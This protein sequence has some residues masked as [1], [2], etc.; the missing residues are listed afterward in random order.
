MKLFRCE[1]KEITDN[2]EKALCLCDMSDHCEFCRRL[3]AQYEPARIY[4]GSYFCEKY[5][6]GINIWTRITDFCK[7]SNIHISMV[8]PVF[9]QLDLNN[10]KTVISG[11]ISKYSDIIDE[12]VVNDFG[13]LRFI[14]QISDLKIIQG[15]LFSKIPRD[16]RFTGQSSGLKN[17]EVQVFDSAIHSVE[18]D[19]VGS[20]IYIIN[21]Q[22]L[23]IGLQLHVPYCYQTVGNI[24]CY[25]STHK[26]IEKKFRPN[27]SCERECYYLCEHYKD[28]DI[29]KIG[30]AVYFSSDFTK[31][32][33]I[34]VER[35]IY[36][37]IREYL[38]FMNGQEVY[39]CENFS[40]LK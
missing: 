20:N 29:A 36:S 30:R 21:A 32:N 2:P 35:Y 3:I 7:T 37:P 19:P 5:F 13:M 23:G 26:M 33:N 28:K 9:A 22:N 10:A 17:C 1:S 18:L 12:I 4:I 27:S 38:A 39:H 6:L 16:F 34:S 40:A 25:A 15:R 11:L 31:V 24:C 8:I 14:K